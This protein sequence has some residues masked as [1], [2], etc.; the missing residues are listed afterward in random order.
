MLC[1]WSKEVWA[2][3]CSFRALDWEDEAI[4]EDFI[5]HVDDNEFYPDYPPD[6]K[7]DPDIYSR[8]HKLMTLV[9][10]DLFLCW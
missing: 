8:Y 7:Y 2:A 3:V 9:P 6:V 5:L 10:L 1:I 4:D